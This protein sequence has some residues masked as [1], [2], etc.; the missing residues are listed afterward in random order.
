MKYEHLK[1]MERHGENQKVVQQL[2]E[3]FS[4]LLCHC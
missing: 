1:Q 2:A 3:L 4:F